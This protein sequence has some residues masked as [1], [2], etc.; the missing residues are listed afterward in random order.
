LETRINLFLLIIKLRNETQPWLQTPANIEKAIKTYHDALFTITPSDL[1]LIHHPLSSYRYHRTKDK[2]KS[3]SQCVDTAGTRDENRPHSSQQLMQ[4]PTA[5]PTKR[6]HYVTAAE[7]TCP[8][9][10]F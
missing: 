1:R 7:E 8:A 9:N 6:E 3:I 4:S 2:R 10:P 5:D